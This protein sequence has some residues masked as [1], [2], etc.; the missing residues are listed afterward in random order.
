MQEERFYLVWAENGGAP[1]VKHGSFDAALA[2][3]ERLARKSPGREFHV[4][5]WRSACMK[6]V[7][8]VW[9]GDAPLPF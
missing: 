3:A 6:P 8:I 1:T 4:L 9:R 7:D 2:E 5:E